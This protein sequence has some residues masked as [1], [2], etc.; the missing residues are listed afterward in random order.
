MGKII[1]TPKPVERRKKPV[2]IHQ[3]K[4]NLSKLIVRVEKGEEVVICRAGKPVAKLVPIEPEKPP[5]RVWGQGEG[6]GF[7]MAP[8]FDTFIPP[9]FEEYT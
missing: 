5:K 6:K 2:N 9:G 1:K 8:D 3:A 4:T 7:W